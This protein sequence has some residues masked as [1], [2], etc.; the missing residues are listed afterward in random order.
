MVLYHAI[1]FCSNMTGNSTLIQEFYTAFADCNAEQM[2]SLYHN[3]IIFEDPVFGC[4]QGDDVKKMWLMLVRPGIKITYA[5]VAAD[6][7][8]GTADWIAEY[9]FGK[10]QRRVINKIHAQFQFRDGKIIHHTDH[11]DVW[12]WSRQAMGLHGLLLGWTP[13]MQKKIRQ[14]ARSRLAGFH[15]PK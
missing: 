2:I 1:F 7:M 8:S 12:K 5:N 4:L 9:K 10:S 14:R 3:E 13:W 15:P 6:D 11:F